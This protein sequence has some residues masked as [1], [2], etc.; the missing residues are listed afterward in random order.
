ML[1]DAGAVYFPLRFEGEVSQRLD[2]DEIELF[3]KVSLMYH[4][5]SSCY[6]RTFVYQPIGD[7][8]FGTVYRGRYR[9]T[10]VAVKV[11]RR[12]NEVC[13]S[14]KKIH[15]SKVFQFNLIFYFLAWC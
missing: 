5:L 3:G 10:A 9:G 13:F 4:S 11:L 8:A 12:Q 1:T 15:F 14:L 6:S 7:G 2:P